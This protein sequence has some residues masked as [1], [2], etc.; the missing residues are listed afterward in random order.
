MILLHHMRCAA[1]HHVC[2]YTPT[3]TGNLTPQPTPTSPNTLPTPAPALSPK[4]VARFGDKEHAERTVFGTLHDLDA[5]FQTHQQLEQQKTP[6]QHRGPPFV[7]S[8]HS[9][10][11][12]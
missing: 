5:I 4:T 8:T 9:V 12:L 1:W 10:C 7:V 6:E 11:G 2:V 3:P